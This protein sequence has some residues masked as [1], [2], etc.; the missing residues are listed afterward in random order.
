M[1]SD[2]EPAWM[3]AIDWGPDGLI[4]A[5]AQDARSGRVLMLAWMSRESLALTVSEGRAVYWSRSRQ[6]LWRKGE[7]SGHVQTLRELRLDCDGDVVL[8]SVEQAGGV[9]CHT[10]RERCF[11]RRLEGG[12]WVSDEPVLK[13]PEDIYRR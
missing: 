7:A 11:Y 6:S 12:R 8:L 3:E 4:P 9:A 2:V 1:S 5:V 13:A 10:G